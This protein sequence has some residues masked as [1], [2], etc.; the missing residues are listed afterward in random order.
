V[1]ARAQALGRRIPVHTDAV[2]APGL[3][4][5]QVDSL[6][7][8]ALSLSAHKFGGP[9]GVGLLYLRRA[10]PFLSQQTGGGQERQRRAGT[11]NV[12]GAVG[13]ALALRRA[14]DERAGTAPRLAV[15]RDRLVEGVLGT[16]P[17][18]RL[19]GHPERRL[20]NHA[21]FSFAGIE[22]DRLVARLDAAG[23]AASNGSACASATWE[24]SHVLLAI[25]AP[26]NWAVG[27]VRFTFGAENTPADVDYVLTVLPPLVQHLRERAGIGASS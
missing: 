8:D 1:R 22:G 19:N 6:G 21:S 16:V 11:E 13:M 12:A 14:E 7:V 17:D 4:P 5:L 23:I 20:P 25:G 15:L 18:A 24:P 9:K 10:T 27:T 2:Q 26:L 3:L